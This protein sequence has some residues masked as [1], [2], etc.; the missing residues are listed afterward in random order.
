M[1]P[2]LDSL[3]ARV[4]FDPQRWQSQKTGHEGCVRKRKEVTRYEG[5]TSESLFQSAQQVKDFCLQSPNFFLIAF[6]LGTT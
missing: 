2:A 6:R 1:E 3:K 5:S 4:E